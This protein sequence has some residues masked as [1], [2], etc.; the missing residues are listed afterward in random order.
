MFSRK[1]FKPASFKPESWR[2]DAPTQPPTEYATAM[3]GPDSTR[4]VYDEEYEM[5]QIALALITSG[6]LD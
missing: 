4:R 3:P 1:S 5:F 6:A 2:G